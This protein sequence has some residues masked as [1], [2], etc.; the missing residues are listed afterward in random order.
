MEF[1][2]GASEA[3]MKSLLGKLGG[4]LAQQYSL[5]RGVRGDIQYINDELTSMQAFLVDVNSAPEVHNRRLK[6]WMKQIR[7]MAYDMEDCIDDFAH[8]LP[9]D[10]LNDATCS[11]IVTRVYELWTMGP[12]RDIAS[13]IAE[14]KVRAQQIAE[15]RTRYGVE[16]P[17]NINSTSSA[18]PAT[19]TATQDI[20]EHLIG[21]RQ[22]IRTEK[23]VGV[24][25]HMKKLGDWLI[26]RDNESG[27][28][29]VVMS[30]VGFGGMG[31]TTIATAVYREFRN[32]FDCRASVTVSQNFDEDEVLRDILGQ[33]K[34]Q[35]SE[36]EQQGSSTLGLDE[37]NLAADIKSSVKRVVTQI[38]GHRQQDDSSSRWKQNKIETMNHDQLVKELKGRLSGKRYLLLIDDIWSAETWDTIR[39]W[40]PHDNT[41]ESR[42][43]VTT[44]FQAVGAACSEGEG[45]DRLHTVDFLSDIDSKRLFNNSVYESKS[46]KKEHVHE[47]IW[48]Y[49]GG[50]PL[51][52]V[53]MAGL[54]ACNP[55]KP[56]GYWSTVCKS[57]LPEQ[58]P[59]R[60]LD[61]VTRILDY[62]YTD[63]PAD[64]QTCLL[65][66]SIFPKGWKISRKRLTRRW[67]SECFVSGKQGLT[68]DEVA[69][70]YFNQLIRRKI[71]RPLEHSSN[72]KVKSFKV[73]DMILEYI[74][75]K[76]SEENFI[77]VVGG[78]WLMPA[79]SNKVR[80]LHANQWFQT[81]EFDE[82]HELVSSAIPDCLEP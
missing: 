81:W 47:D 4:L 41:K 71:I 53:S 9:H 54:V 22:L 58:V 7:D 56:N 65:F 52:I 27:K 40:L 73:H 36:H 18:A 1:V 31:K 60:T 16:N 46:S 59:A 75:S 77:T 64:L 26:K 80:R 61:D 13:N 8:R 44:R 82:R 69:E 74:V 34:P 63:L 43:I 37:K 10:S 2:V 25:E 5:I 24:G 11:F 30:I 51:A 42:V 32:E 21:S 15:R 12:R 70:T 38:C 39:N 14:L 48:K 6:D 23:P 35:D 66:L 76:S 20:A 3:T 50:L 49:C 55:I 28:H 62:C 45:T 57:L 68:E 17:G 78:H 67:I 72:G 33:I 19:R 79:P 29:R